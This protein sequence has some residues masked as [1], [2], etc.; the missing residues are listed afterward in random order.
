MKISA[1]A[2]ITDPVKRQDPYLES[3]TSV[4]EWAD[5]LVIVDGSRDGTGYKEEIGD[6]CKDKTFV[7]VPMLWPNNWSWEELPKHL[8]AGLRACTGDFAIKF[9]VDYVFHEK[10]RT[11][12]NNA[13][14]VGRREKTLTLQKISAVLSTMFYQKGEVP[15]ILNML[16]RD[17][18]AFGKA[19]NKETDLCYPI[20]VEGMDG[21]IPYGHV[22][23][24][25]ETGRTAASFYNYDYTFKTKEVVKREFY[26]FSRARF[27][28]SGNDSWG[29]TEEESLEFF[30]EMMRS[31][32][33]N[34][35]YKFP[36]PI[37]PKYIRAKLDSLTPEQFGYNG[38][39]LL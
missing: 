1:F 4:L 11:T 37:Q 21:E 33:V 16:Y 32:L 31:R 14:F 30:L 38:W 23:A 35:R 25:S 34:C 17:K 22:P 18:L 27:K 28:Y 29:K 39:G 15:F 19:T 8:N 6:M 24:N 10:T 2:C 5:E 12:L 3:I 13:L 20:V 26:N 36:H 9:D 7:Y